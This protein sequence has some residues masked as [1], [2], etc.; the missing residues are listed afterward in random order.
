MNFINKFLRH[1]SDNFKNIFIRKQYMKTVSY[2]LQRSQHV[3]STNA[4]N[5]IIGY[6]FL[7]C[8]G[9]VYVAVSLGGI[10]RLTES[11]LSMVNWKL[12]GER[13]PSDND[14]WQEEFKKYQEFPEYKVLNKDMSLEEFKK[15]W[16][17]E[18][19]HR[20]WG[21]LIGAAFFLPATYFWATKRFNKNTKKRILML[22]GLIGAQGLMGWHMVKSGLE[23]NLSDPND[24]PRVSQYRLAAHLSFALAL[25][26]GFL[27][28]ALDYLAPVK[29]NNMNFFSSQNIQSQYK[30]I[31]KLRFFAQSCKGLIFL[32]AVSGAFVAG[33][34]AGLIYNSFPKMAESWVPSEIFHLQ[35]ILRNFTENPATVQFDHR[36]LGISTLCFTTY[37]GIY[38]IKYKLH[39]RA[40]I[41]AVAMTVVAYLQASLG[42]LTLLNQ[43]PIPLA[44][45]HQAGS[46]ALLSAVTWYCHETKFINKLK[47]M[48]MF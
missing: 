48:K 4:S 26:V 2:V 19:A 24:I 17:M 7:T 27:H 20:M 15:I 41:A 42:I 22:G 39:R 14:S 3:P 46:V 21:R 13:M 11:G 33:L 9:M 23:K 36:L 30:K 32:T 37:V 31:K 45:S 5:K 6:W 28:T 10:T 38:S 35:P 1:S 12:F 8:G 44:A 43:V 47:T 34:D 25:Y 18:Y 16:W 29:I 40:C